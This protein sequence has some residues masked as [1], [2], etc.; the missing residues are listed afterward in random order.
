VLARRYSERLIEA[1]LEVEE[2]G[3]P[4][5]LMLL[6]RVDDLAVEVESCR[7]ELRKLYP[8]DVP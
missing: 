8:A 1:M 4:D 2:P 7:A 6:E 3:L 5:V